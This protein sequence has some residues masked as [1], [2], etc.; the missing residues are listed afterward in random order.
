LSSPPDCLKYRRTL[1]LF[2]TL[3]LPRHRRWQDDFTDRRTAAGQRMVSATVSVDAD[4]H[5]PSRS[6]AA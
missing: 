1:G 5:N 3:Q 4:V 6:S 2:L